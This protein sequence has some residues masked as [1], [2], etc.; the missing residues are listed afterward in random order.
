M[1]FSWEMSSIKLELEWIS[2]NRKNSI[3]LIQSMKYV[4]W[5][6]NSILMPITIH[7]PL[8]MELMRH[9]H[10]IFEKLRNIFIT[11]KSTNNFMKQMLRISE[12][13]NQLKKIVIVWC[14]RKDL[15][16][17]STI[18]KKVPTMKKWKHQNTM[19]TSESYVSYFLKN[20]Q[21]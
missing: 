9:V 11:P 7:L 13:L 2:T 12:L 16:T 4:P 1:I 17:I 8:L 10:R 6:L 14:A 21:I 3:P 18:W 19:N 15:R 5:F 20:K